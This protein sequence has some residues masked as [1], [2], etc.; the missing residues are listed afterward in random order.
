MRIHL[1]TLSLFMLTNTPAWA[2]PVDVLIETY[3][4]EAR[5]ATGERA[6]AIAELLR[7]LRDHR[8]TVLPAPG[9]CS[10]RGCAI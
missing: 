1:L 7:L 4:Q 10:E 6:E 3:K 2:G 5:T 8:R 9:E